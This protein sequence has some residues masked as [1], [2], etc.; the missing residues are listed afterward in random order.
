MLG[1]HQTCKCKK[2]SFTRPAT[3]NRG[4]ARFAE[5][6]NNYNTLRDAIEHQFVERSPIITASQK[7]RFQIA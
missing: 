3:L 7:R 2:K 1:K 4:K 5:S 6:L